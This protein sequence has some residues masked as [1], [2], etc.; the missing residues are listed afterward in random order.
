MSTLYD[1]LKE[2]LRAN[3]QY[4]ALNTIGL[5]SF[6][7]GANYVREL[8]GG[9]IASLLRKHAPKPAPSENLPV[10]AAKGF[11]FRVNNPEKHP[12]VFTE[13]ADYFKNDNEEGGRYQTWLSGWNRA[14]QLLD[15]IDEPSVIDALV[16]AQWDKVKK[17]R[18]SKRNVKNVNGDRPGKPLGGKFHPSVRSGDWVTYDPILKQFKPV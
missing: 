7:Q 18:E 6:N 13:E 11:C 1:D 12:L 9:Q 10:W 14:D 16:T 5:T 4:I 3:E 17:H 15:L 2:F 8:L